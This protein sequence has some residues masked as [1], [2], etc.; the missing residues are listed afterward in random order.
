MTT[1]EMVCSGVET[2]HKDDEMLRGCLRLQRRAAAHRL[3]V[4]LRPVVILSELFVEDGRGRLRFLGRAGAAAA[5]AASD[6]EGTSE[7]AG[8][9]L[10]RALRPGRG[11]PQSEGA[12]S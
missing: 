9:D 6:E 11:A 5:S 8:H 2:M 7:A 12:I 3:R 4:G 10:E 1:P